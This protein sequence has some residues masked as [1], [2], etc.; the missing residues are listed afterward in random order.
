MKG[1]ILR[2]F[3]VLKGVAKAYIVMI[4]IFSLLTIATSGRGNLGIFASLFAG[5]LP[6]TVLYYDEKGK[7]DVYSQILPITRARAVVGN[8]LIGFIGVVCVA[9]ITSIG[10][11]FAD[12]T[13]AYFIGLMLSFVA[14]LILPSVTLP[15]YYSLGTIKGKYVGMVFSGIMAGVCAFSFN[16]FAFNG[17]YM[18]E[19]MKSVKVNPIIAAAIVIAI[20]C[21]YSLSALLSVKLY[22][23]REL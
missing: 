18:N 23:K 22:Q 17:S 10:F 1:I 20:I 19:M 6:Y 15:I 2:E 21:V 9:L 14:G 8:Y 3:Y 13:K 4:I 11:I 12:D 5:L 7:W 16:T